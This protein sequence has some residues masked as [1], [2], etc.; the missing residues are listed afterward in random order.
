MSKLKRNLEQLRNQ[1]RE[2]LRA[3]AAKDARAVARVTKALPHATIG[4]LKQAQAQSVIARENHFASWSKL[5]AAVEKDAA[6]ET[7]RAVHATLIRRVADDIVAKARAGDAA[8]LAS[9]VAV[10]K[11]A[12]TEIVALLSADAATLKM[13]V[14][15][16]S[17]GFRILIRKCGSNVHKARITGIWWDGYCKPSSRPKNPCR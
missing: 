6:K 14:Q 15:A 7:R 12:G 9:I 5:K 8:A 13:V 4:A 3:V 11:D 1:A 2:L 10:G 17:Q 16:I